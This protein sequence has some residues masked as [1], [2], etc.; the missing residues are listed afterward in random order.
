MVSPEGFAKVMSWGHRADGG[1]PQPIGDSK[2]YLKDSHSGL[3]Q[4]HDGATTLL[5]PGLGCLTKDA[6]YGVLL[7]LYL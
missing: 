7:P 2:T 4:P 6:G 1:N 5:N 3:S